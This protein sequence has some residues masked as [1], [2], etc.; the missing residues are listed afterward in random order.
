MA[1]LNVLVFVDWY[2][3]GFRGGGPVRSM[4]NM[5]EHLGGKVHFHIVTSDTDYATTTPYPGIAA[6]R[7]TDLPTGE[8]VWYASVKGRSRTHW[9]AALNEKRWDA[10]YINGMFSLWYSIMPLWLTRRTAMRRIVVARGMLLP[11]PV[12]Q[13][14]AK[15][16]LFLRVAKLLGLY[17]GVEFQA[18]S[19]EEV[20]SIRRQIGLNVPIHLVS[21]LARKVDRRVRPHR[22][23]RAGEALLIN[24]VRIATEKNIHLI[25]ESLRGISGKVNFDLY[26]PVYHEAYWEQCRSLI[27]SLP[28]NITF[29]YH[30]PIAS[31][32][33]PAVLAG[34]HHALFMP[35]EGDN[36]GHT[37]VEAMTCGLPLL[38][39][40]T[41]PWRQLPERN[42][43]WD[44][45]LD[46][47]DRF[48]AAI[49]ELVDMDQAAFDRLSE[50]AFS[51][52]MEQVS[53]ERTKEAILKML[54]P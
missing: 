17:K 19:S 46:R 33:V 43:G 7:W 25:I 36:F 50:G 8:R 31:E 24:V 32:E 52:G 21:N 49:Q 39:G 10:V 30:G 37:M 47:M 34:A 35:N 22:M 1:R 9:K 40:D 23:K 11:G 4:I 20:E 5:V 48:T 53:D 13:G 12:G 26:G 18:T 6:D 2:R 51:Y 28:S 29:N 41:S 42:A 16:Q 38:I 45:P 54:R 3:P 14:G 27:A 15:K 44:I